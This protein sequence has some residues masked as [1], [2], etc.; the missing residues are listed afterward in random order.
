MTGPGVNNWD[1]GAGKMIALRESMNMQFRADAFNA[2][3][4]AQFQNPDSTYTDTNFG[5][6]TTVSATDPSREFQFS[7]KMLW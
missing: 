6:I 2:F 7:L 4:H 5:K 1:I 3:N